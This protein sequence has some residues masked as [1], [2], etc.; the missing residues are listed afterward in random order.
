MPL[1]KLPDKLIIRYKKWKA[2]SFVN[3]KATY[4]KLALEGQSPIAMI[5]SCCDSRVHA[6]SMFGAETGEFFIHRNIANLIPPYNP[7]GDHHGT[8]AAIEFAVSFL[9]IPH[10]I[11]L[12][13]SNCSGIKNGYH[14]CKGDQLNE[15]YLFVNKWLNILRPAYEK[16]VQLSDDQSMINSLEKISIINSI[17]NLSEF[18]FVQQALDLN[19]VSIHGL[20]N[21]IGTGKL[22]MLNPETM[23][24]MPC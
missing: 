21:D 6:T 1:T 23:T 3:N 15:D 11:I 20:W 9:K 22:E 24:F 4:E 2:D 8:S 14:L 18:P 16:L 17:N 10:I 5:I 13:H 19:R 12:G 7:D